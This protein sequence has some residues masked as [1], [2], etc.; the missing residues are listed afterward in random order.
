VN[1]DIVSILDFAQTFLDAAGLPQ[2]DD[3]Q[4]RSLVPILKGQTP[5]D[6][7][8]SYYYH[9]YEYPGSPFVKRHYG[10]RTERYKIIHFYYDIDAWELYD[11]QA[12]PHELKNV[13]SDPRYGATVIDLKGELERLR[14][15]YKDTD[16]KK[17]LPSLKD[18]IRRNE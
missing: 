8:K 16:E 13:Y 2:P 3:M 17:F 7:R 12:D 14:R 9:Y 1:R 6:W 11:L 10:V 5:A 4:G 15:Q 18:P